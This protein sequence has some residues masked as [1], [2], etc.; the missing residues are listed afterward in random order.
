MHSLLR[1]T[2]CHCSHWHSHLLTLVQMWRK[3]CFGRSASAAFPSSF[4]VVCSTV[5]PVS[6]G[7]CGGLLGAHCECIAPPLSWRGLQLVVICLHLQIW[8]VPGKIRRQMLKSCCNSEDSG[9]N[10]K[11]AYTLYTNYLHLWLTNCPL[12]LA[13][14]ASRSSQLTSASLSDK[15]FAVTD[16]CLR[17]EPV[18]ALVNL[19]IEPRRPRTNDGGNPS[20]LEFEELALEGV[21]VE[22]GTGAGGAGL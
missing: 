7:T 6:S 2:H 19:L 18:R 11:Y 16:F 12:I 14:C 15:D 10:I 1:H 13:I 8:I 17:N 3:A 4:D 22:G 5:G 21:L 9:V 20:G